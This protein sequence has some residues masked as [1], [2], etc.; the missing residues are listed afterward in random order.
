ML[1]IELLDTLEEVSL[2]VEFAVARAV[3][4]GWVT[5]GDE[6]VTSDTYPVL[7]SDK[8]VVL[9]SVELLIVSS[10]VLIVVFLEYAV[11]IADVFNEEGT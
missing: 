11:L 6:V 9:D 8:D 7:D 3:A 10:D 5:F 1:A 2:A 4:F